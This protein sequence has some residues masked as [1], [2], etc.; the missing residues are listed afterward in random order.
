ML[1]A[2]LMLITMP[3]GPSAAITSRPTMCRVAALAASVTKRKSTVARERHRIRDE[4][5]VRGEI[6]RADVGIR[7]LHVEAGQPLATS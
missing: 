1:E 5:P 7:D 6:L 4:S 2:R 3:S